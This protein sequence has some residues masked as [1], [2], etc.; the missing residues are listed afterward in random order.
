MRH[1]LALI[2]DQCLD[3]LASGRSIE[4]CAALYPEIANELKPLLLTTVEL[5]DL[6]QPEPRAAAVRSAL[7][8]A[9]AALPRR[10]A[11]AVAGERAGFGRWGLRRPTVTALRWAAAL[12]ASVAL[13]VGIGTASAGSAPGDL[14]YPVKLVTERVVFA[15]TTGPAERAELR[16][17][18]ADKRLDELLRSA[19][20]SGRIDPD[21]LKRLLDEATLALEQV[22]QAP[23]K[24]YR[25]VLTR[26]E[27]A[28]TYQ[29]RAFEYL[30][31]VVRSDEAPL[32]SRAISTC[33]E[34]ERWVRGRW[35]VSEQP[36]AQA[37]GA[38]ETRPR[39]SPQPERCWGSGCDWD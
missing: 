7:V 6:P 21:L 13:V 15:L 24:Q 34:R 36:P 3:A 32:L 19:R 31:G 11:A 28:N 14:L 33:D 27:A 4:E 9:G 29:R 8:R 30:Q 16:L 39:P 37:P 20:A 17:S 10:E 38:V 25:R 12:A 22:K 35:G 23:D 18:F 1:D 26:V 5:K 2:L